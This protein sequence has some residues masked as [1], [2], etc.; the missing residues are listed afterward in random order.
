M[1]DQH[2]PDRPIESIEEMPAAP[3]ADQGT[4][5]ADAPT[6]SAPT[7]GHETLPVSASM[8]VA[9]AEADTLAT[10]EAGVDAAAAPSAPASAGPAAGVLPARCGS[11]G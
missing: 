11:T 2:E 8:T 6:W 7:E 4:R 10:A 5:D 3:E 9:D 1:S